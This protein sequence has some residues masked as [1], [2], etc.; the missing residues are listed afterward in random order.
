MPEAESVAC[1]KT[2]PV[3][4]EWRDRRSPSRHAMSTPLPRPPVPLLTWAGA[5]VVAGNRRVVGALRH[6]GVLRGDPGRFRG[7]LRVRPRS[8]HV[9][10]TAR[11]LLVLGAFLAGWC[12]FPRLSSSSPAEAPRP[13]H[14]VGGRRPVPADRPERSADHRPG[15]EG[16][17]VPGVLRLHAL[18]GHLS[19]HAVRG[20]G[21]SPGARAATRERARA[22]RHRRS[23]ARH[24]GDAQGLSVELRSAAASA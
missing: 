15:P 4:R 2:G 12:Y 17:A 21:D 11:L 23:R 16:P 3:Q 6:H 7:L 13:R 14:A 1:V 9:P 22:V 8:M 24:A 10:R 18:P 19:D 20:L 5:L